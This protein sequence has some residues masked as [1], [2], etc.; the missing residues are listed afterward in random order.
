MQEHTHKYNLQEIHHQ[1]LKLQDT[2]TTSI[3]EA[4]K[5]FLD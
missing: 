4:F 3:Q 5:K 2:M 1:F